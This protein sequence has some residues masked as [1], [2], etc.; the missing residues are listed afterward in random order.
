MKLHDDYYEEEHGSGSKITYVYMALIMS[1]VILGVTALVFWANQSHTKSDGSGYA[2]ALA[3]KEAEAS[4]KM[5]ANASASVIEES[6]LTSDD[7]DIWTLPDTGR[8]KNTSQSNKNNGTVTNQTTGE[9]VI[10]GSANASD[11]TEQSK[12]ANELA[13]GQTSVYDMTTKEE[14]SGEKESKTDEEKEEDDK[15]EEKEEVKSIQV[16]HADGTREWV[17]VNEDITRNKYDYSNLKFKKPIM[18]YYEDGTLVSKCGVDISANQGDVDFSKLKNAGCDFVMLKVGARGYSSG[19]IVSDANFRDN[20]KAAR[21][22]GLDIGVYFCSQAVSKSEAREEA[23][24][25]LDAISGYSIKYPVAFVMETVNEDMARIE[26]LDITERT[27]I[28]KAFL[29]RIE[30]AGYKAMIYGDKEW[31]LTMVDME[32]LQ[33]FDVW[34]A[35]DSDEPEYPYEFGMWQYD[36]DATVKG[37]TGDAAMIMSFKDYA[38]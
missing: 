36:S 12:T 18:S 38:K 14:V 15:E 28:A 17:D 26:A 6:K 27:Q 32:E 21:K 25:V 24:E 7:L 16:R 3:Q 20:V 22:A 35:Q 34:F 33:D 23:D 13:N 5:E 1:A 2:A 9:T 30:D 19:N 31:L 4:R 37:I 11:S 10:D 8:E 29:N